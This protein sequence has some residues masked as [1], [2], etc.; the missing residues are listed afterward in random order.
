[1]PCQIMRRTAS[2]ATRGLCFSGFGLE[3]EGLVDGMVW[4]FEGVEMRRL[5]AEGVWGVGLDGHFG[6]V[7]V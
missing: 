7:D 6:N 3:F 4:I 1:M 5:S 2:R